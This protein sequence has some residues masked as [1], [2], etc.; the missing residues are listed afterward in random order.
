MA[1]YAAMLCHY[2]YML[3]RHADESLLPLRDIVDAE[4]MLI[5]DIITPLLI[6]LLL[7]DAVLASQRYYAG[8]ARRD[9]A[10]IDAALILL[11]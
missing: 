9:D 3:L 2:D 5:Q 7:S 11:P 1:Y 10:F 8:Y 4:L 6:T